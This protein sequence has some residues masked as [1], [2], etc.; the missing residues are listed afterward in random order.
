M[1][2]RVDNAVTVFDALIGRLGQHAVAAGGE[3]Y[4]QPYV[5]LSL[6]TVQMQTEGWQVDFDELAAVSGASALFGYK[7]GELMPKYAHLVVDAAGPTLRGPSLEPGQE[8]HGIVQRISAATGF[9]YAWTSFEDA[10]SAWQLI[11][12]TVDAVKSD[13]NTMGDLMKELVRW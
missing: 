7:P 2:T 3:E 12:E 9:G 11:V 10:E 5:Y 13:L 8:L 6:H 1:V 4:L